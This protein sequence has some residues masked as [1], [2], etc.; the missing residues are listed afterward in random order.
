LSS[1]LKSVA[2]IVV[3]VLALSL[4]FAC[5]KR[6]PQPRLV[7][8]NVFCT[9]GKDFLEPYDGSVE[10]TPNLE[11][12]AKQGVVFERH[13]TETGQSG[14]AFA[15]ILSG[16][17]AMRHLVYSHPTRLTDAIQTLPEA[18][19]D[20][21]YDTFFWEHQGMGGVALN[22]G[23]GVPE[24]QAFAGRIL[25]EDDPEFRAVLKRLADDPTYK[26]FI[27][28][29]YSLTHSV[30]SRGSLDGFCEKYPG[31]CEGIDPKKAGPFDEDPRRLAYDFPSAVKKY[32]LR[33]EDLRE[34]ADAI[35]L[36][37]KSR[38]SHTD[39]VFG[40]LVRAID[41]QGL[42]NE[43]L[44][45]FTADH[46]ET[47]YRE[48]SL[49]KWSHSFD[50]APDVINVP[51]I[52]RGRG[53]QPGRYAGV[54]SSADVFPTLAA[55]AQVP[56]EKEQATFGSNLLA[57][58]SAGCARPPQKIVFSHTGLWP[59]KIGA[60]VAMNQPHLLKFHPRY[61]PDA[62]WVSARANDLLVKHR[63]DGAGKFIYE[64]FDLAADPTETRNI[65]DAEDAKQRR[66]VEQLGRYRQIL[67][68]AHVDPREKDPEGSQPD[69]A[70]LIEQLR[71]LGYID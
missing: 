52:V 42:A 16:D 65:F 50:L 27:V 48:P 21:G 6:Q 60:R 12:F 10:Y 63:Y 38:V 15:S 43:S 70:T 62:I 61:D 17:H 40:G 58:S 23:Q 26:A 37:Y 31:Q 53:I 9:L 71:T 32:D 55:L 45:A 35:E 57:T 13:V 49:F 29:F 28:S 30:Y 22:Y 8:L 19:A 14:V 24:H 39:A 36:I 69:E 41:E 3:C 4:Q 66:L 11:R 59:P 54:S 67:I 64:A 33:G 44:I 56:I 1:D 20:A 5:S 2:K 7:M 51:F 34:L 25:Q 68:D 46:G 18:F 47:L